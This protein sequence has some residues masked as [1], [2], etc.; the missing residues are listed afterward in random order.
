MPKSSRRDPPRSWREEIAVVVVALLASLTG[1]PNQFAFDDVLLVQQNA[2]VHDLGH[3]GEILTRAYWPPPFNPELYRPVA[4]LFVAIQYTLADGAPMLFRITSDLLYAAS[5]LA[6]LALGRR[7]LGG[8]GAFVAALLFAAHPVHVE[9]VALAVNQGE[10]IVAILAMLFVTEYLDVRA[11]R[12]PTRRDWTVLAG[13]Y[14]TAALTKEHAFV[15]PALLVAAEGVLVTSELALGARARR[16]LP[17]FALLCLTGGVALAL[18]TIV[19]AGNVSG[20]FT[21]EALQGLGIGARALT[22]LGVVPVWLRL[23]GWPAHLQVDYSPGEIVAASRFGLRQAAGALIVAPALACMLW[24]RRRVP[25][26]TFGLVWIVITL[27]PVSNVLVPTGITV[28]ERTLFLPSVGFVIALV[29]FVRWGVQAVSIPTVPARRLAVGATALLVVLGVVRSAQRET[30]WRNDY[31]LW[32]ASAKDAPLSFRVAH[33]VGDLLFVNGRKQEAIRIYDRAIEESVAPWKIRDDFARRLH[34]AGDDTA[35]VVQLRL[36]LAEEPDQ[37][38]TQIE[39]AAALIGAGQYRAARQ[40]AERA[41][42]SGDTAP[43]LKQLE[44]LADSAA[45]HA[46]PA[47]S[48]HL[49]LHVE[50]AAG[51]TQSPEHQRR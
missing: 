4:S 45:T 14:A 50:T 37:P 48:V 16:L 28:A 30:I 44:Y 17:G 12:V 20:T 33:A 40:V 23:F 34:E 6:V 9:S 19:L 8:R 25:V 15:L 49:N 29:G 42:D 38:V 10:L 18:R 46:L 27:F 21:A 22:M 11:A 2:R 31:Q 47:G 13:L 43:V 1:L 3:I 32:M 35:A 7:V 39:L 41:I 26:I 51:G 36:S 5:A 24:F